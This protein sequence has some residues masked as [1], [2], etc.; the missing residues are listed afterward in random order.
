[1]EWNDPHKLALF[2]AIKKGRYAFIGSGESVN[3]PVYI[4]DLISGILLAVEN[5]K[6]GEIYIVGG[7]RPV[8]KMELVNTIADALG[9]KRPK[10][11]IPHRLAWPAASILEFFGRTFHFEPILTRARVMMMADNFGY[12]IKKSKTDLHYKPA[13]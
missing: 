12:S 3:H 5:G 9:V 2:K 7:E 11:R 8:T 6:R 4:D 13:Q 1:M 10:M